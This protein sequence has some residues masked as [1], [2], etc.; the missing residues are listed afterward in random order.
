MCV[1]SRLSICPSGLYLSICCF[2]HCFLFC[3]VF[4]PVWTYIVFFMFQAASPDRI[5]KWLFD[6]VPAVIV[7][8]MLLL[9]RFCG[10][11]WLFLPCMDLF[12]AFF[13]SW[14]LSWILLTDVFPMNR[15]Q[16]LIDSGPVLSF[17]SRDNRSLLL[18]TDEGFLFLFSHTFFKANVHALYYICVTGSTC[19]HVQIKQARWNRT[20]IHR[21]HQLRYR[22]SA[23]NHHQR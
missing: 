13:E 22:V 2:C 6:W 16:Y 19:W 17:A 14:P 21:I 7:L 1:A 20:V 15:S 3:F 12:V 8:M 23:W 4:P 10:W 11:V 5:N 9:W 18:N